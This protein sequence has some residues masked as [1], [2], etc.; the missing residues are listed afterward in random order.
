[1]FLVVLGIVSAVASLPLGDMIAVILKG[2]GVWLKI[3]YAVWFMVAGAI[4]G[5]F[6]GPLFRKSANLFPFLKGRDELESADF[7]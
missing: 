5:Y 2:Q 7:G 1:M 3:G 4:A 6:Y